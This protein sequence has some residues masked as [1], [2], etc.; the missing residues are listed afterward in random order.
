MQPNK[1]TMSTPEISVI[2]PVYNAEKSLCRCIDS[3]LA[4][5]YTDFELLLIDDGS[6]DG[7]SNICDKYAASNQCIKVFHQKNS[8]VSAAR[9]LGLS[10]AKGKWIVFVDS[11]DYVSPQYLSDLYG[12]AVDEV[13]LVI[14]DYLFVTNDGKA[15]DKGYSLSINKRYGENLFKSMLKEQVL[16]LRTGPVAK[17]FKKE[18]IV[19]HNIQFPIEIGFGEDTCFFF[20][21]LIFTHKVYCAAKVNYF[22]VDIKGSAINKKWNFKAEYTC[23]QY[24]KGAIIKFLINCSA[25][26]DFSDTYLYWISVF[27]HRAITSISNRKELETLTD[28]DWDFFNNYFRAIS[29]KTKMDK[30]MITHYHRNPFV[31]LN[32]LRL[33]RWLKRWILKLNL[34]EVYFRFSKFK[35]DRLDV[36]PT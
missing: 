30:Y 8:G 36:N 15:L 3:I 25:I 7:G 11:D 1:K 9:N 17:L 14:N 35:Q 5:I 22:Y 32:Y 10:Q 13:D 6:T 20:N 34:W 28:E 33:S 31:V 12:Q 27:L 4:Q 16:Y 21:Y 2:V 18:I 19:R 24:N 26:D 29:R 23:Y